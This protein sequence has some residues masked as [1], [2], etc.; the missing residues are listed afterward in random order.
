M[1]IFT[2]VLKWDIIFQMKYGLYIAGFVLSLVWIGILSLFSGEAL[3]IAVP[4]VLLSD[5]STMGLLFIGAIL[6]F[7]R[8]QGSINALITTP[9]KTSVYV[10]SKLISLTIFISIFSCLVVFATS[11]IKGMSVNI[12]FLLLSVVLISMEY[13][14]LG[15][16]LSTFFKNF[17]D[18]IL[19]MG[20]VFAVF[21]LP[22]LTLF[23]IDSLEFLNYVFYIIPS[24]GF[25][26]L[27]QG[28]YFEQSI[29]DVL[30]ALIYNTLFIVVLYKMCI[31]TFNTKIIGRSGDIDA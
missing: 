14:L 13:V 11:L 3:M 7:E 6:F 21:N 4:I 24:T 19:P 1:R 27:L 2:N 25:V 23:N 28:L 18:F 20:L 5:V 16:W 29:F 10:L 30:Y 9:L 26:K 31:K 17:T 8:G 22:L 12:I 15:F